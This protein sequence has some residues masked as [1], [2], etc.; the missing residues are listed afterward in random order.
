MHMRRSIITAA[1]LVTCAAPAWAQAIKLEFH[2]GRVTLNAQNVPVRTILNQWAQQ[3]GTR[4]V[5]GD[6]IPGGLV[7]LDLNDVPERLAL[8]AILRNAS[9]Y[10]AGP[11]NPGETGA[12]SYASILILP[13][14]NAAAAPPPP[15]PV[16]RQ[17]VP[18]APRPVQRVNPPAD[19]DDEPASDL[20]PVDD[21]GAPR[22][23]A[24]QRFFNRDGRVDGA[25]Q[26]PPVRNTTPNDDDDAPPPAPSTAPTPNNPFGVNVGSSQPG[27]ISPVPQPNTQQPRSRPDPEP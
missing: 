20:Q 2:N 12:S 10:I 25:P 3:G 15:Q 17:P 23:G 11:R 18:F 24:P 13:V 7:T 16:N 21:Q 6:R 9:G 27:V 4:V 1:L 8:D 22:P 26:P 19:P 14:S 5:N